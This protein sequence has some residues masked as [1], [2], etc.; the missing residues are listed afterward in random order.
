[1]EALRD[2]TSRTMVEI[3]DV[4]AGKKAEFDPKHL[5]RLRAL[6]E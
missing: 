6:P 2:D 3:R 5:P 4:R 1:V